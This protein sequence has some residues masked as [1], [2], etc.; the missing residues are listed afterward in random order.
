VDLTPV[1]MIVGGSIA[2]GIAGAAGT[3]LDPTWNWIGAAACGLLTA[4]AIGYFGGD[5]LN[6]KAEG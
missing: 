2:L 3:S 1:T 6:P 5:L 4:V